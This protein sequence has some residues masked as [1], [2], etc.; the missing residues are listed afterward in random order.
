MLR[1]FMLFLVGM[2]FL[3]RGKPDMEKRKYIP[4]TIAAQE[5]GITEKHV[6]TLLRAGH[7]DA[8][9]ISESGNGGPRSIRILRT[10]IVD[11]ISSRKIKTEKYY[12]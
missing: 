3:K 12:E 1:F 7:L 2:R 11:F 10:S 6:Y 4:V 5:L 9:D 8:I